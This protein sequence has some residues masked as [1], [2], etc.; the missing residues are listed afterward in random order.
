[1][2]SRVVPIR[3]DRE[4]LT[5]IDMLVSL[6]IYRSRSEAVRE[7]VRTGAREFKWLERVVEAVEKIFQLEEE[8]GDIPIRLDGA[9]R[10]LLEE[11]RRF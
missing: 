6:G 1:M 9:L 8:R 10:Q 4:T 2:G 3:L 5:L 11:R 7:L